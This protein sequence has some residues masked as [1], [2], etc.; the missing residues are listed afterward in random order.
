[1]PVLS[2]GMRAAAEYV[3]PEIARMLVDD[4]P[5]AIVEGQPIPYQP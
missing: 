2:E 1:M 4:N 3:G 5:R